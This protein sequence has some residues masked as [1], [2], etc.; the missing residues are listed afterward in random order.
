MVV[1][2]SAKHG[3]A[4]GGTLPDHIMRHEDDEQEVTDSAAVGGLSFFLHRESMIKL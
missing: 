4:G 2:P 3:V 1:G